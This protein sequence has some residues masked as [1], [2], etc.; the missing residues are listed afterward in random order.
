VT[1]RPVQ[2]SNVV[3]VGYEPDGGQLVVQFKSGLYRYDGVPQAFYHALLAAPSV[4]KFLNTDIK[5]RYPVTS[6]PRVI[7][8]LNVRVADTVQVTEGGRIE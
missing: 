6:I 3:A 2:S 7:L 8:A 4:G 5:P 1:L